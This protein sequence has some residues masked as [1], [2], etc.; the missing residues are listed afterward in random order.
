MSTGVPRSPTANVFR[1]VAQSWTR[2]DW[3]QFA[4]LVAAK[5]VLNINF[6]FDASAILLTVL[7]GGAATLLFGLFGA[8]AALR[9]RPAARLRQS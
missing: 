9:S 6:V 7:G 8:I 2:R 1:R 3:W 4:A 5:E